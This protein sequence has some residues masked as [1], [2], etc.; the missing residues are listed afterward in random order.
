LRTRTRA[1]GGNFSPTGPGDTLAVPDP[2]SEV[3]AQENDSH[4]CTDEDDAPKC[5]QDDLV[6]EGERPLQG[7]RQG[8]GQRQWGMP[9]SRLAR[10]V[11]S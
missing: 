4:K 2:E 5:E 10:T 3:M 9:V 6:V 11:R 8:V 7:L 1:D